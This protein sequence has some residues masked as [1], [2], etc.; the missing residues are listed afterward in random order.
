MYL[1]VMAEIHEMHGASFTVGPWVVVPVVGVVL[2]VS[3]AVVAVRTR[4]ETADRWLRSRNLVGA[5][6]HVLEVRDHLRRKA[7][8]R[9][10]ATALAL[11]VA[12]LLLAVAE[13]SIG[14]LSLPYL[15]ATLLAQ[16][17]ASSPRAPRER[18][19]SLERRQQG[20]FAPRWAVV[21]VRALLGG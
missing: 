3:H 7:W 6:R 9:V 12:L 13:A 10:A 5:E 17:L 11:G 18:F 15:T 21:T 1:C 8:S 16:L 2:I 19:A 14:L 4:S 20:F